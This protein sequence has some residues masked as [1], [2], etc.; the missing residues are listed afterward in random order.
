MSGVTL[1]K[2]STHMILNFL[3]SSAAR[4]GQGRSR[5]LWEAV[6]TLCPFHARVF[7]SLL[8]IRDCCLRLLGGVCRWSPLV[9]SVNWSI[10]LG[11]KCYQLSEG[12]R[13]SH[14][15]AFEGSGCEMV[16]AHCSPG[17]GVRGEGAV[18]GCRRGPAQER[19]ASASV[20]PTFGSP[21]SWLGRSWALTQGSCTSTP[22]L[23]GREI[24]CLWGLA[25]FLPVTPLPIPVY[26]A[27]QCG[28]GIRRSSK[29]GL[30]GAVLAQQC[31][32]QQV[33]F[34]FLVPTEKRSQAVSLWVR[35]QR[36]QFGFPLIIPECKLIALVHE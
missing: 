5:P 13:E 30:A 16:M 15:E 21:G 12:D 19:V 7:R 17:I 20:D 8:W 31:V 9:P 29:R 14:L 23:C 1:N 3:L 28:A 6:G 2:P 24:R 18:L 27:V 32:A 10:P 22:P 4:P 25:S 11:F 36:S 34:F 26:S 33:A 35:L